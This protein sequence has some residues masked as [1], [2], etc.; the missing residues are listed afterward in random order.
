MNKISTNIQ[1]VYI[2]DNF[3]ASDARGSFTKIYNKQKFEELSLLLDIN[4][5]YYSVSNKNVI[6]GLHFQT[7]PYEHDK[8]VKVIKGQV[9]DVIVDLRKNSNTYGKYISYE[10]SEKTNKAILIPKGCAHGFKC[11]EDNTI[12]MYMVSTVYNKEHDSGIKWNSINFNWNIE[13]PIIS[14][15]DNNFA[16]L[17][18]FNSPF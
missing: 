1:G 5:I 12:M 18:D 8:L 14:E 6:R 4:E 17:E 13:N 11:L 9:Q 2:L 16:K 7:P 15:R 10:L 3:K